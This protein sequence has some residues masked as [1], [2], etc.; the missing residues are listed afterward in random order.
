LELVFLDDKSISR[1][2][3][4]FFIENT[5]NGSNLYL[6]DLNSRFGSFLNDAQLPGDKSILVSTTE[7][8]LKLGAGTTTIRL[9]KK[10]FSL[11]PTRLEKP[12]KERLKVTIIL[13]SFEFLSSP[14]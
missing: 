3:L 9:I 2:H 8:V 1:K 12:E 13:T 4:E 11:C 5:Q 14:F 10:T 7:A 6:K